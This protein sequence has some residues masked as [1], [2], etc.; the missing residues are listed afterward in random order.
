[1]RFRK[2]R[3]AW[4]V[5][6]GIACVLLTF[7]ADV[8]ANAKYHWVWLFDRFGFETTTDGCLVLLLQYVDVGNAKVYSVTSVALKPERPISKSVR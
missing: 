6:C 5:G 1:M 3:I 2:L 7:C 8:Y 4:S